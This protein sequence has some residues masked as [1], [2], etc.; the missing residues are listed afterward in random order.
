MT[1]FE[2]ENGENSE[3]NLKGI[4]PNIL[5]I[6]SEFQN[7]FK[8]RKLE[9]E[10]IIEP[11]AGVDAEYDNQTDLAEIAEESHH[12]DE[13]LRSEANEREAVYGE[14]EQVAPQF[15]HPCG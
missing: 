3:D 14:C 15:D 1:M 2:N 10:T 11:E 13:G 4:V 12:H 7:I 6:V 5:E 8:H 9:K